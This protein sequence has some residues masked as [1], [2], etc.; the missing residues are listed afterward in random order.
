MNNQE[1]QLQLKANDEDVKG[2]YSNL[3][4]I[5]H[6]QEEFVLDFCTV[7]PPQGILVSRILTSPGHVKRLIKALKENLDKYEDKYGKVDTAS[8]PE[9]KIGF[10]K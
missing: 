8:E 4:M 1:Q 6:S 5:G 3:V 7:F 9:T 10:T 2:R